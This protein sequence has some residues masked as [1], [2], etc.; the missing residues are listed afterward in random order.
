LTASPLLATRASR[1]Q[2]KR[3]MAPKKKS[4][5]RGAARPSLAAR[6]A[7][8]Q[9]EAM[10]AEMVKDQKKLEKEF[11]K[12]G[13]DDIE[14]EESV[15]ETEETTEWLVV[16]GGFSGP[17]P[18]SATEL[19][20]PGSKAFEAGPPL[21]TPRWGAAA[22][23]LGGAR[24]LVIGGCGEDDYLDST[25]VIDL[26][27]WTV[28]PGPRMAEARA[29]CAAVRID[30]QHVLVIG[31]YSQDTCEIL[32][33][34]PMR[35]RVGPRML[36]VRAGCAAV[37]LDQDRLMIAGGYD[38]LGV[39]RSS[40]ILDLRK[41]PRVDTWDE[42]SGPDIERAR[43]I[44][45]PPL[46]V[47]RGGCAAVRLLAGRR[48]LFMGGF[49]GSNRVNTTEVLDLGN[50]TTPCSER[51]PEVGEYVLCK[52]E[53]EVKAYKTKEERELERVKKGLLEDD[54]DDDE[55]EEDED[56]AIRAVKW[57][58]SQGDV[59]EV[60]QVQLPESEQQ[61]LAEK[62]GE[63]D[64]EHLERLS[65]APGTFRIRNPEGL[66][67]MWQPYDSYEVV[68][69][70]KFTWVKGPRMVTRRSGC[71][72]T[73][74]PTAIDEEKGLLPQLFVLGG[75]DENHNQAQNSTEFLAHEAANQLVAVFE[76][77]EFAL[78]SLT[79]ARRG[80]CTAAVAAVLGKLGRPDPEEERKKRLQE[81]KR[82][83]LSEA[84]RREGIEAL[85]QA[86]RQA[87]EFR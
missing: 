70:N 34:E 27:E 6:K 72:A 79:A 48:V 32:D 18:H 59:A 54:T 83:E 37:M 44:P 7:A 23:S 25:E 43:F 40:E 81:E 30:A 46:A 36:G 39:L 87:G 53:I 68:P 42:E 15:A 71:T 3:A 73:L 66:E 55:E 12:P 78:G 84:R 17:S 60:M 57:K 86:Q 38:L 20:F 24:I 76:G 85:S 5:P 9:L 11:R 67:S 50:Y 26:K 31:G 29:G 22:V 49:D 21:R 41:A 28:T 16:V 56:A 74:F 82:R 47:A 65:G 75:L 64:D 69:T 61:A 52:D 13:E 35:F 19:L 33:L 51:F 10:E 1:L 63:S 8:E 14:E 62:A 2:H 80:Y 77:A 58:L 45:G 4:A